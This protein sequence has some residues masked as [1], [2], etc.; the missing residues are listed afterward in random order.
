MP[1]GSKFSIKLTRATRGTRG[2]RA[3]FLRG[4]TLIELLI[5]IVILGI[6][7]VGTIVAINPLEKIRQANDAKAKSAVGIEARAAEAYAVTHKGTYPADEGYLVSEGEL[8]NLPA[9][10]SGYDVVYLVGTDT[11]AA[12][13]AA[14]ANCTKF[15]VYAE[16]KAKSNR[17]GGGDT[18]GTAGVS[19]IYSSTSGA[20]CQKGGASAAEIPTISTICP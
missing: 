14:A 12:C 18:P 17:E 6:L 13:S 3:T 10:P 4:F 20:S 9:L 5:V 15:V 19:F 7:A 2:T 1:M 11:G 16:M 8:K